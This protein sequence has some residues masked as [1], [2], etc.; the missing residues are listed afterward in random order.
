MSPLLL[1]AVF[2][3]SAGLFS[4]QAGASAIYRL[5][6]VSSELQDMVR[7][8]AEFPPVE[9]IFR[10]IN[11]TDGAPFSSFNSEFMVH[12]GKLIRLKSE[13][14]NHVLDLLLAQAT[15]NLICE[16]DLEAGRPGREIMPGQAWTERT[17]GPI[18]RQALQEMTA[19]RHLD[20][21]L[22]QDYAGQQS[23]GD[24]DRMIYLES[25][26]WLTAR[27]TLEVFGGKI[28]WSRVS[29]VEAPEGR[30]S[31]ELKRLAEAGDAHIRLRLR[32][33]T[34]R[35]VASHV[36]QL[37]L[38]RKPGIYSDPL[39]FES[40][41]KN[42]GIE[43]PKEKNPTIYRYELGRASQIPGLE[44]EAE[45][46]GALAGL[47]MWHHTMSFED[48]R[49]GNKSDV[50]AVDAD[51][52]MHPLGRLHNALY[53]HHFG[54]SEFA[55]GKAA[56]DLVLKISLKQF[57]AKTLPSLGLTARVLPEIAVKS[58]A[59][60]MLRWDL[61]WRRG[62]QD[63]TRYH[64]I[65]VRLSKSLA[66]KALRSFVREVENPSEREA[67]I[68]SS[69]STYDQVAG[70]KFPETRTVDAYKHAKHSK[71]PADYFISGMDLWSA[72]NPGYAAAFVAA[73]SV[74]FE[75]VD[76]KIEIAL[77]VPQ[78]PGGDRDLFWRLRKMGFLNVQTDPNDLD[79]YNGPHLLRIRVGQLQ[80]IARTNPEVATEVRHQPQLKP[81]V[82]K[83]QRD[84]S[85]LPG[86]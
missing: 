73:L 57:L 62:T 8:K 46:L 40:E 32:R 81:G 51:I 41:F 38:E 27:Q 23:I 50:R 1:S 85:L 3:L 20:P 19:R 34:F 13:T 70:F 42:Q 24:A 17:V 74:L 29:E 68:R 5:S 36:Y 28:P 25:L 77:V 66:E 65:T 10:V 54:A 53:I 61:D 43:L 12:G 75:G 30:G 83:A 14:V 69:L 58:D 2:A 18:D 48:I 80:E 45:Q 86:L 76:P 55:K 64:P 47:V 7:P 59:T 15:E 4:G 21:A 6:H 67:I 49:T 84:L 79:Y 56:H 9:R 82:W 35:L 52:F 33:A 16:K 11:L 78:T 71:V 72:S 39:P 22:A 37:S 60:D 31:L 63:M 44:G 26:S